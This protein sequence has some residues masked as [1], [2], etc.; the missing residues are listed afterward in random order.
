MLIYSQ[1]K[2]F[3]NQTSIQKN[4]YVRIAAKFGRV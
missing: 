1:M 3:Y 2:L 4:V